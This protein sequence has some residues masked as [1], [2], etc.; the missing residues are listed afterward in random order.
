MPQLRIQFPD[1]TDDRLWIMFVMIQSN[2]NPVDQTKFEI[3][4]MNLLDENNIS[5][6]THKSGGMFKEENISIMAKDIYE[7]G[8]LIKRE[9]KFQN[10]LSSII[11]DYLMIS[12]VIYY[13]SDHTTCE[14]FDLYAISPRLEAS[15]SWVAITGDDVESDINFL[16][17]TKSTFLDLSYIYYSGLLDDSVKKKKLVVNKLKK[18]DPDKFRGNAFKFLY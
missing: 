9:N 8:W 10:R 13:N 4:L 5:W 11:K 18:F 15:P 16:P 6:T 17:L 12:C 1:I 14:F 3:E 2:P 7:A